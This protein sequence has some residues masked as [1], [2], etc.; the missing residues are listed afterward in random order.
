MGIKPSIEA[1]R[2][3]IKVS[4]RVAVMGIFNLRVQNR[5]LNN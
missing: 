1:L 2:G 5:S 3:S 4:V